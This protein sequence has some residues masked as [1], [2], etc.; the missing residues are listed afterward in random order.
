MIESEYFPPIS[1]IFALFKLKHIEISLFVRHQKMG[2]GNR[3]RIPAANGVT[4]LSVPLVGG[5]DNRQPLGRVRIDNSQRWQVRHWRSITSA[6][7]R[8]PWFEFLEPELSGFYERPYDLLWEW[9]RDLLAWVCRV[10]DIPVEIHYLEDSAG[11]D[12]D[13]IRMRAA[14]RMSVRDGLP[15]YQQVFQDRIGFQ[16]DMSILDLICNEGP[17]S[18]HELLRH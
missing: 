2:F 11:T 10:M 5:R 17:A 14:T 15:V 4:T 6:Y 13:L 1:S 12:P 8:S 3:M 7:N 16:P 18:A 9:N